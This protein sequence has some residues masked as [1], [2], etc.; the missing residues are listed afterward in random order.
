MAV[1]LRDVAGDRGPGSGT[2]H[3]AAGKC[4]HHG[5]QPANGS[6]DA[7]NGEDRHHDRT[8]RYAQDQEHKHHARRR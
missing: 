1:D 5:T 2:G 8:N 6:D 4:R 7:A 3:D